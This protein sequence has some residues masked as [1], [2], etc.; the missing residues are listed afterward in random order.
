MDLEHLVDRYGLVAVF[1]GAAIEGDLTLLLAGVFAQLGYFPFPLALAAG[2]LGSFLGDLAWFTLGRIRGPWFRASRFY[3]KVG[4]RIERLA[5]RLGAAQLI[6]ARF[7]YGTKA[8]SMVFWGL[9]GMPLSRFVLVD[10]IGCV[11]GSLVFTGLGYAV[12]GSAAVLLGQVR[13]VQLW[14]LGVLVAGVALTALIHWIT[15]RKLH[16]DDTSDP[17]L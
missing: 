6:A 14:L 12:S 5:G 11:L 17:P 16:L 2:I 1:F 15:K 10:A 8:A 7:V 4:P 13:R 3:R 9:H